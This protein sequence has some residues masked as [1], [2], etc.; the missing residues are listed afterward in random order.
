MEWHVF[1]KELLWLAESL[2]GFLG[3]CGF[4]RVLLVFWGLGYF[5]VFMRGLWGCVWGIK[6]GLFW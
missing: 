2:G 6:E 1:V 4:I 3:W 5:D